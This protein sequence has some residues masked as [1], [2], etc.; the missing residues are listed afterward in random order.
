MSDVDWR[1]AFGWAAAVVVAYPLLTLVSSELSRRLAARQQPILGVVNAVRHLLLPAAATW[2]IAHQLADLPPD[3]M[4][5]KL[6]DTVAGTALL[7]TTYLAAKSVIALLAARTQAPRLLFDIAL[8]VLVLA[9]RRS[10][11][12]IL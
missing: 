7:F 4:A 2:I 9:A 6:I 8:T 5:A 11:L 1:E 10:H 12:P 3:G